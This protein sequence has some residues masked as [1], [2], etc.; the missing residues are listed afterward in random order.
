MKGDMAN[1]KFYFQLFV[2]AILIAFVH[3]GLAQENSGAQGP[4]NDAEDRQVLLDNTGPGSDEIICKARKCKIGSLR[5]HGFF[6]A[7][8]LMEGDVIKEWDGKKFVIDEDTTIKIPPVMAPQNLTMVVERKGEEK[9]FHLSLDGGQNK[10]DG[11]KN[12]LH[13]K[14][15]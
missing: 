6:K 9:T 4:V 12:T 3:F 8:G 15:K 5:K 11:K 1:S 14:K 10:G 7:M 13:S 2:I